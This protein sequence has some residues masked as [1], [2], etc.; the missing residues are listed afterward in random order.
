MS[1]TH[2]GG[3]CIGASSWV[4][5]LVVRGSYDT[6]VLGVGSE[7]FKPRENTVDL[8]FTSPPYFDTEKYADE[9]TQSYI[10]YPS[11][12]EWIDGFLTQTIQNC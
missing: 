8:C 4:I 11:E 9:P 10:K 12:K 6:R 3:V 7:E 2:I 5:A 1:L